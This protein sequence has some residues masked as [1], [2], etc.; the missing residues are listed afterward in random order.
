MRSGVQHSD[1]VREGGEDHV[2][3]V[4]AVRVHLVSVAAGGV[5]LNS[6]REP[7][8]KNNSENFIK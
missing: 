6:G 8:G 3:G 2:V 4:V 1:P 7:S 5:V